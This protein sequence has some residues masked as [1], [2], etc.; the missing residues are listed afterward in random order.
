MVEGH[1]LIDNY[2]TLIIHGHHQPHWPSVMC[3]PLA[4][5]RKFPGLWRLVEGN[6]LQ[7]HGPWKKQ[8]CLKSFDFLGP[9]FSQPSTT[10]KLRHALYSQPLGLPIQHPKTIVPSR[11]LVPWTLI[12]RMGTQDVSPTDHLHLTWLQW[13]PASHM[14]NS[15]RLQT[16]HLWLRPFDQASPSRPFFKLKR[17]AWINLHS[18]SLIENGTLGNMPTQTFW[19]PTLALALIS[20]TRMHD[21]KVISCLMIAN[22][23]HISIFKRS[24]SRLKK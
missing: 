22:L 23:Y 1:S 14:E 18:P 17:N 8:K 12:P 3:Q 20:G 21:Q 15:L 24:L 4:I 19:R 9:W 10:I 7:Q 16:S 6:L 2:P 11:P 13:W 5:M